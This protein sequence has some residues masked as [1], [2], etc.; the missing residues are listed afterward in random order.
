MKTNELENYVSPQV[1]IVKFQLNRVILQVSPGNGG[2][3]KTQE[4]YW[5]D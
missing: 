5:Y 2:I 4:E 1:V 3:E